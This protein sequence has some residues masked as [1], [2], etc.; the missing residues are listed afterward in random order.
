MRLRERGCPV[1]VT[2]RQGRGH[3]GRGGQWEV[4]V[5]SETGRGTSPLLSGYPRTMVTGRYAGGGTVGAQPVT[6]VKNSTQIYCFVVSS[7]SLTPV[8]SRIPY[9]TTSFR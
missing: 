4:L 2:P 6:K 8:V 5:E 1:G 7:L 9:E 3:Q